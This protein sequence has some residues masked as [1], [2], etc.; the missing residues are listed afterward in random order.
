[1][2]S[3]FFDLK[4]GD[5]IQVFSSEKKNSIRILDFSIPHQIDSH[6]AIERFETESDLITYDLKQGALYNLTVIKTSDLNHHFV[7]TQHHI[8]LDGWSNS[9]LIREFFNIY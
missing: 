9:I 3:N 1:M 6:A 7:W 8:I 5:I 4:N 2:T